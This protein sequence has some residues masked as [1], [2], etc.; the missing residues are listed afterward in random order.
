MAARYRRDDLRSRFLNAAWEL[1]AA[2]GYDGTTIEKLIER[3]RVSKGAF[4]HYF[5]SKED[6]LNAIVEVMVARGIDDAKAIVGR[7]QLS[8]VAKLG[9]FLGGSRKW[10]LSNFGT[11]T[12]VA[13][14]LMRDENIRLR[15]RIDQQIV[16]TMQPLVTQIILQGMREGSIHVTDP[17]GAAILLL[18]MM[19]S[20]A[21]MQTRKL[22]EPVRSAE[23][24]AVLHRRANMYIG[25][26]ERI[27]GLSENALER[28]DVQVFETAS[29]NLVRSTK[30][31]EKEDS[32]GKPFDARC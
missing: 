29:S 10:R 18:H 6:L 1:F 3:V 13:E 4:Y 20:I 17:E 9:E 2:F 32:D 27:L 7:E 11:V 19:N 22:L 14:V 15:H 16:A 26:F 8:A 25:F 12:A 30:S 5:S 31:D 21:E 28:V 24:L 23:D